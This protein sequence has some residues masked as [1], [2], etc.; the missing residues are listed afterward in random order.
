MLYKISFESDPIRWSVWPQSYTEQL[1]LEDSPYRR[2]S[3]TNIKI[4]WSIL[5][6]FNDHAHQ[7]IALWIL[8]QKSFD[9]DSM[10]L[11]FRPQSA[12]ISR[13]SKDGADSRGIPRFIT[14]P[15]HFIHWTWSKS[16]WFSHIQLHGHS[17]W[18]RNL[19]TYGA[20]W[21]KICKFN[22]LFFQLKANFGTQSIHKWRE[23]SCDWS[24]VLQRP[25]VVYAFSWKKGQNTKRP[26]G[27]FFLKKIF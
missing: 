21:F 2:T 6:D 27:F 7:S 23:N 10:R 3:A 13:R 15:L 26:F 16:K 11:R 20:L 1:K 25:L 4:T 12:E 9:S 24:K 18:I 5:F 22:L 14:R 19:V 8:Y 17:F